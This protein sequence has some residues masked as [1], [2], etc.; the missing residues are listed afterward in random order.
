MIIFLSRFKK[1]KFFNDL[2]WLK[3]ID[4][5]KANAH[6]D[7][8]FDKNSKIADTLNN[9]AIVYRHLGEYDKSITILENS[10]E[11][12]SKL[13]ASRPD[14]QE[15]PMPTL[16]HSLNNLGLLH[17]DKKEFKKALDY[18]FEALECYKK[19]YKMDKSHPNIASILNNIG[20]CYQDSGDYV[21]SI[22]YLKDA[23]EVYNKIH[24]YNR[25]KSEIS[26][27]LNNIG[28]FYFMIHE[29]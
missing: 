2:F 5:Y 24:R 14:G 28:V 27:C 23:L 3:A 16:G 8:D 12:K 15:N 1:S 20:L 17:Q 22:D 29:K 11:L 10:L 4:I 18:F 13:N 21:K 9:I 6:N 25:R 26:D 19:A 7:T